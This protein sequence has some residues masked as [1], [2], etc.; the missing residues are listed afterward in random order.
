MSTRTLATM[1][2]Q[3]EIGT[4]AFDRRTIDLGFDLLDAALDDP[5]V[6]DDIPNGAVLVD[7]PTDEPEYVERAIAMGI[8]AIRKGRDVYFRHLPAIPGATER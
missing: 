7:L 4:S 2:A 3:A 1:P 8:D 6:L 5:R